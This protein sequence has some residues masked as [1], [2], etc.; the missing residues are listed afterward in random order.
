MHPKK[1]VFVLPTKLEP[2]DK[3][4]IGR[5]PWASVAQVRPARGRPANDGRRVIV[6]AEHGRQLVVP[7]D[8]HVRAVRRSGHPS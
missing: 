6:H 1:A 4:P 8:R 5:G 7:A 2:G 3:V